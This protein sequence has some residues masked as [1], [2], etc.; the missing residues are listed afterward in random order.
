MKVKRINHRRRIVG[1]FALLTI[2]L[3]FTVSG[4][5]TSAASGPSEQIVFS[6]VGFAG[7][8]AWASPVGFWIWC[9]NE[10]TGPYGENKRC[11]GAMYVYFQAITVG[12]NGT[13]AE[14]NDDTYTMHVF[15]NHAG[16]LEATLHNLDED[17]NSGPRN[18]VEFSVTTSAGTSSGAT[19]NAVV[20]VTGPS[21]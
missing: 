16:V 4:G 2:I 11:A 12:V 6:G 1:L 21:H 18:P 13:V 10:G 15:S 17:L 14:E 19:D 3:A 7:D 8:G 20:H 9:Q 5:R